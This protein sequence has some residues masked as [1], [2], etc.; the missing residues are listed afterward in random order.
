MR[1]QIIGKNDYQ[2]DPIKTIL[3]NREVEDI[4]NFLNVNIENTYHYS[5]LDNISKAVELLLMHIDKNSIIYIQVDSDCDGYTSAPL[6]YNYIKLIAPDIKIIWRIHK[7]K[8][9][10]IIPSEVPEGVGLVIIPDAGS[11]QIKEHKEL[12]DRGIDV[13]VLDHH[14]VENNG[15][16][17]IVDGMMI[18]YNPFAVI[19]NNQMCDY[20]NKHLSGVGIVYK[21]CQALDDR[22]SVRYA[23][24]FLDLVA[25]GLIA[26]VMDMRSL[27]TRYYAYEGLKNINNPFIKALFEKQEFSTK[28]IVSIESTAW[29]IAPLIN[30]CIRCGTQEEKENMFKAFLGSKETVP[31][32]KRGATKEEQVPITKDMARV[33]TNVRSRQNK[34][35]D[36]GTELIEKTIVEYNL[37]NNKVLMVDVTD[38]LESTLTGLVATRLAEKYSRPTLLL[39]YNKENGYFSGSGRGYDKCIIRDFKKLIQDTKKFKYAEGHNNAFGVSILIDNVDEVIGI[40]NEQL[41]DLILEDSYYDVDFIIPATQISKDFILGIDRYNDLWSQGVNEPLIAFTGINILSKDIQIMGKSRNTLK[42]IYKDIE[43][44][45]FFCKEEE[46]EDIENLADGN[47]ELDIV[48]KCKVNNFNGK[49]TAQI[50]ISDYSYKESKAKKFVF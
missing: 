13:L 10:G 29:Y 20:P 5:L 45:K 17:A 11:N 39:R 26:D 15:E 22:L 40:L 34:L 43:F 44:V 23:D 48:G 41:K 36:K 19:V 16:W 18:N 3:N 27:E 47:I 6:I 9:H 24:Q 38:D 28:G 8:E 35:R 12:H 49:T 14:E 31:Y 7:G 42:F 4:K 25:L 21:F 50:V 1:Y 30:A 46:I 32:K 33:C 2:I 37:L